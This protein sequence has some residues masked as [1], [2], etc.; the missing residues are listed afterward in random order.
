MSQ[1]AQERLARIHDSINSLRHGRRPLE[2]IPDPTETNSENDNR[3][4]YE[5]T[6][7]A[8]V[9]SILIVFFHNSFYKGLY[10]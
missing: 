6:D 9:V 4:G 7:S 10:V 3:E 5:E 1:Q 8:E 2:S